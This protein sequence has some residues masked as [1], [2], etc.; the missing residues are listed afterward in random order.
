MLVWL[1]YGCIIAMLDFAMV[2]LSTFMLGI[3]HVTM[4]CLYHVKLLMLFLHLLMLSL[5]YA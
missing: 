4:L 2:M 1:Y 3:D 5:G